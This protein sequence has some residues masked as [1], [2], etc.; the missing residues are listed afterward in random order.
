MLI[1]T[2]VI[3]TIMGLFHA[4]STPIW[5]YY[6]ETTHYEFIYFIQQ[7]GR[8]PV[9][10]ETTPGI[11]A[12]FTEPLQSF[13]EYKEIAD[14]CE[15]TAAH[16]LEIGKSGWQFDELAGYYFL[17]AA[18]W[19]V[20]RATSVIAEVRA[21][22][23]LS[24]V[25]SVIVGLMAFITVQAAFPTRRYLAIAAPL[26]LAILTGYLTTMSSLNNDAGAVF[27]VSI[28]VAACALLIRKP[29]QPSAYVLLAVGVAL[30]LV[31]KSTSLLGLPV[32]LAGLILAHLNSRFLTRLLGYMIPLGM[33]VFLL[34]AFFFSAPLLAFA[35]WF[36]S[37]FGIAGG[38]NLS[39]LVGS[40]LRAFSQGNFTEYFNPLIWFFVTFWSGIASGVPS[41]TTLMNA[42]ALLFSTAAVVGLLRWWRGND[43]D[44]PTLKLVVLLETAV[45]LAFLMHLLRIQ[46]NAYIPT[47]RHFLVAVIPT[48]ALL[49]FGLSNLSDKTRK[50]LPG[51]FIAVV[52]AMNLI[53]ITN[54]LVP[55]FQ[56]LDYTFLY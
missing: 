12:R 5:A 32:A 20:T 47:A 48:V 25:M 53:A 39:S 21:S 9:K 15:P 38:V 50:V 33:I 22:R 17:N 4:F 37:L 8:R 35:N 19:R 34:L 44:L 46:P 16:C 28:V 36:D 2:L 13:D 23:I 45:V 49:L 18:T 10:G 1:V 7:N 31:M 14:P 6:D 3:M 55:Y 24:V 43:P 51:V 30:C 54:S 26:L 41:Y 42:I 29:R 52:L 27:A 11:Y 56:L 40:A